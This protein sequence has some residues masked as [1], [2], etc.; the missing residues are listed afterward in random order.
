VLILFN[1]Y[2]QKVKQNKLNRVKDVCNQKKQICYLNLVYVSNRKA[3]YTDQEINKILDSCNR[4]NGGYNVTGVLLYSNTKF[5]Q[6]LEGEQKDIMALYDKIKDDNRY[7]NAF[8]ISLGPINERMFPSWQMGSQVFNDKK[9]DFKT[10]MSSSEQAEFREILKGE[11]K[12]GSK[13]LEL[14]RKFLV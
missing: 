6:Y 4:N 8:L 7:S 9:I 14:I 1:I 13:A 5:V 3:N 2:I 12:E 11:K 10:N